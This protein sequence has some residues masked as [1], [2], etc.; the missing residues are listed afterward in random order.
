LSRQVGPSYDA[1]LVDAELRA[2][3]A[4]ALPGRH[5]HDERHLDDCLR[6]LAALT[7]VEERDRRLLRWAILWHDAVYE[8]GRKDNE[9]RSA[10]L[11]RRELLGCG[12]DAVDA[13]EVARLI[14]LTNGHDWNE[15]DRLGA[16]MVSID[17]AI[18]G[19]EPERYDAYVG[20]VRREYAHLSEDQWREGR[21]AVLQVLLGR[22]PLYPAPEFRHL[23]PQARRNM[24]E[25]L[26]RL[27]AG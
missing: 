16:Q 27:R 14:L 17:L 3:A 8:A 22:Q 11:A 9:E 24:E 10:E 26:S 15:S 5:Y 13:D 2:R 19:S 18:L 25:E 1:C 12:V 23:E 6:Q 4:Y 20:E 7:D 21:S